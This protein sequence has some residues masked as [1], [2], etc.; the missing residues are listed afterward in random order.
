M[1]TFLP[2]TGKT[3]TTVSG[4]SRIRASNLVHG[5][6]GGSDSGDPSGDV[7]SDDDVFLC[8]SN[9]ADKTQIFAMRIRQQT[10]PSLG[11]LERFQTVAAIE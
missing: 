7:A 8:P 4:R 9:V 2:F 5:T 6:Q 11:C 3:N 10:T 1:K